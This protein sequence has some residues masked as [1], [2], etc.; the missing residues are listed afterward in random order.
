VQGLP[1]GLLVDPQ[2]KIA[3][4]NLRGSNLR[5]TVRNFLS[6]GGGATDP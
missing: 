3:A 6:Q 5:T 4:R 1:E 2:G